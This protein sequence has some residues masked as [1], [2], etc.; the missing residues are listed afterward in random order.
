M[1]I[2]HPTLYFWLF[3]SAQFLMFTKSVYKANV[4]QN[5]AIQ[6]VQSSN[7]SNSV[8][9]RINRINRMDLSFS[10]TRAW[11]P[12]V[13]KIAGLTCV[14]PAT[15]YI[16]TSHCHIDQTFSELVLYT[17]YFF[18]S[19]IKCYLLDFLSRLCLFRV[20]IR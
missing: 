2:A 18:S 20:A 16:P 19:S 17:G 10:P 15:I 9:S 4:F 14:Q 11:C 5:V 8:R 7:I 13:N 12:G 6:H 1:L 3:Q